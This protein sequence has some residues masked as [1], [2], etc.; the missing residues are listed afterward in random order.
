MAKT[1]PFGRKLSAAEAEAFLGGDTMNL[2]RQELMLVMLDR[3]GGEVTI[4]VAEI[5]ATGRFTMTMDVDQFAGTF[6]LKLGKKQ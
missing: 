6:T 5:D 1:S 4:P 3:L 2:V